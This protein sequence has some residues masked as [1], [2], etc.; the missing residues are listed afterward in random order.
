MASNLHRK[1]HPA[2]SFTV[3]DSQPSSS[4]RFVKEHPDVKAAVSIRELA[5]TCDVIITMLPAS[6]H[7]LEVYHGKEGLLSAAKKD[8]LMVDSSTIDVKTAKEVAEKGREKGV[9]VVDAPVS[10]GT[11]GAQAGTLTFM[12]GASTEADF[13]RARP[14]L[15][16]MGKNIVY[17]G[18]NGNGQ[19]AKICNNML[20]GITMIAAAETM[21]LGA[22]LG[23][24]PKLLASILNTSSGRCWSTDTY[25]PCPGVMP[26]VPSSRDYE[27]GFGTSLMAKDLGLA[28]SAAN[29]VKSTIM[30]GSSAHQLYNQL[31]SSEEFGK[32]DFSVVFKWLN[33]NAKRFGK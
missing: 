10:G 22:R 20:L 14:Y 9:A 30:L 3:Y 5:Q 29:E 16:H 21:N 6:A 17:C 27:G 7:V 13:N 11:G 28:V 4:A 31:A 12:T 25:N 8:A 24:N 18:A 23:M 26:N 15:M 32:K 1:T 33:D 2:T 19:V